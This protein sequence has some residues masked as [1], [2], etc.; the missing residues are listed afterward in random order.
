[1][2]LELCILG[3]GSSGNST[4]VRAPWGT[5]LIDAGFGPRVTEQRLHDLGLKLSDISAAIQEVV[6]K[7]G[8]GVVRDFAG[9]G[10]GMNMHEEPEILNYGK[11][12]K[13]PLLR[14]GMTFAIEPMITAGGYKVF[15]AEDKWTVKTCD[16]SLAAHVEDTVLIT[17]SGPEVLTRGNIASI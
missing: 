14:E 5:F 11:A 4:V 2:S 3:S 15:I 9:H 13:G 10:I 16:K 8:F 6:E 17:D 1:M 7:H 12:G